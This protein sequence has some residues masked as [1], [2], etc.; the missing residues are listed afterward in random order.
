MVTVTINGKKK[1]REF[2]NMAQA[3]AFAYQNGECHGAEK[4]ELAYA[5]FG[6]AAGGGGG[7]A[8]AAYAAKETPEKKTAK[9][10]PKKDAAKEQT[11]GKPSGAGAG[12]GDAGSGGAG[13]T[14]SVPE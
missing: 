2:Q 14:A 4:L 1:A 6:Q 3:L 9:E 5:G 10:T 12:G 7:G 11:G 8:G 13:N